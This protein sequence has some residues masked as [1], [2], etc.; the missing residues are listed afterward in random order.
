MGQ[1][2]SGAITSGQSPPGSNANKGI[3]RILQTSI[4]TEAS[5]S[6]C[7][8]SYTGH[9]LGESTTSAEIPSAYSTAD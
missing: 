6:E 9:S 3:L 7:L 2:Q 1:T 4:V 5:P 8:V